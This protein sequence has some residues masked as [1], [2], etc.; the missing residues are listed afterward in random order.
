MPVMDGLEATRLIRKFEETGVVRNTQEQSVAEA[1][2]SSS[3]TVCDG[4]SEE[5]Y[6]GTDPIL[7]PSL[8]RKTPIIAVSAAM[9]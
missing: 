3:A 6:S 7:R 8:R 2:V 1:S 5:Q 4:A 9:K